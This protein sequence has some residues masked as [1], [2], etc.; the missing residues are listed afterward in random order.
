MAQESK[1]ESGKRFARDLRRV[2]E[3]RR[4]T[5][6]DLHDETKIP[7]GLLQAFEETALFDHPQFNRVYLRSF[8]R[9]YANVL[10]I[11]PETAIDALEEA[12]SD[13]YTGS[14]AIEYL[15][16]EPDV[17][18]AAGSEDEP[19][20]EKVPPLG[21]AG[22]SDEGGA[23]D[24]DAASGER[25]SKDVKAATGPAEDEVGPTRKRSKSK[26][27]PP[28][29]ERPEGPE[30]ERPSTTDQPE[31]ESYAETEEEDEDELVTPAFVSTTGET[32][33][34]YE[35]SQAE[36]ADETEWTM[37]SPPSPK[38]Q[39]TDRTPRRKQPDE[40]NWRWIA[41][42]AGVI[43]VGIVVW[44]VISVTGNGTPEAQEMANVADTAATAD[45]AAMQEPSAPARG[46]MPTLGD[47]MNVQIVAAYGKVDP[48]RVTV[49][50]DLRRP[51]WIDEGDS[52]TF[53]PTNR[54]VVEELLDN[55][56]L[57]I[58]GATY[59][60]SRRDEAGR[61]VITR[62]SVRAYFGSNEAE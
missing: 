39:A 37:Q 41:G 61:I 29:A 17:S 56:E 13:R 26:K 33:A 38:Q 35:R 43:I 28:A 40:G 54:I 31:R 53:R 21:K 15:G 25:P 34:G 30:T 6:E 3:S 7:L 5:V 49:D 58:E 47:T 27:T 18:K 62:D 52:M 19:G 23:P 55:I 9:T 14:L 11:D 48:I 16:E 32:A 10:G 42:I 8:V 59:P 2:R 36:E 24:D 20:V 51:Y 57:N 1:A 46:P 44:V 22:V 50:D 45:T 60:T 12:L 4:L